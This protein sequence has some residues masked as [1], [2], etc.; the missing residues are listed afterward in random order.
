MTIVRGATDTRRIP[1]VVPIVFGSA[2]F[3][4]GLLGYALAYP[5]DGVPAWQWLLTTL[6]RAA[7]L[8][9]LQADID[10]AHDSGLLA[11]ARVI[12]PA[13]T[14]SAI[15]NLCADLIAQHWRRLHLSRLRGHTV[16]I[17]AGE[18]GAAFFAHEAQSAPA[19]VLIDANAAVL[20]H[21]ARGRYFTVHGDARDE[22]VLALANIAHA[23]RVLIACGADALNLE[24]ADR[25][26]SQLG[27]TRSVG[28]AAV[29][30][31]PAIVVV[32]IENGALAR[33]LEREDGFARPPSAPGV[34]VFAFNFARLAA[35]EFLRR[36]PLVD[37]A[38]LRGSER[39][40]LV[41]VGWSAFIIELLEQLT[42]VWPVPGWTRPLVHVLVVN[43][44]AVQRELEAMHPEILDG[45][46][47]EVVLIELGQ[48][49]SLVGPS[50]MMQLETVT[51]PVTALVIDQGDDAASAGA[52]LGLR[53]RTL[54][55]NRWLAPLFVLLRRRSGPWQLLQQ[56]AEHADPTLR[57]VPIGAR[58]D[59]CTFETLVGARLA[60]AKR[61]HE[62]YREICRR[63]A[64][65]SDSDQPWERLHQTY[66]Q[67][68]LRAVDHAPYKLHS[69]GLYCEFDRATETLQLAPGATLIGDAEA[70]ERLAA[71]EHRSWEMERYLEGW[72]RGPHKDLQRRWNPYLGVPYDQLEEQIKEYDRAQVRAL[73]R[74]LQ[75]KAAGSQ[76]GAGTEI[77]SAFGLT[78]VARRHTRLGIPHVGAPVAVELERWQASWPELE[79]SRLNTMREHFISLFV[80]S[81]C[82]TAARMAATVLTALQAHGVAHRLVW[83]NTGERSFVAPVDAWSQTTWTVAHLPPGVDAVADV[84]AY[85]Q[86]TCD[87]LLRLVPHPPA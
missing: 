70:L 2:G 52:A 14:L 8:F 23:R 29:G 10:A 45:L 12:A 53:E 11:L 40:H 16:I 34:E 32:G 72:R 44:G 81:N 80:A 35:R 15:Y 20:G 74:E 27:R 28:E 76:P 22:R 51:T 66:R 69:A 57:I 38:Q 19:C 55:A 36:H 26:T 13:A 79:A 59:L 64:A 62:S 73:E 17:G 58:E 37:L 56:R 21:S 18:R 65:A 63:F 49:T 50:L 85:L 48:S 39:I 30:V 5:A 71:C 68:S 47:L 61:L 7:A 4:L 43:A 84:D 3:V 78:A 33:Q 42:R 86:R 82:A 25:V 60:L 1:E 41:L 46:T 67:A 31:I 83:V 54:E 24:I 6:W 75:P 87:Q 9:V 77:Q